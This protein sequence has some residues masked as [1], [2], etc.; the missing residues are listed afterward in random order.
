[1]KK[2]MTITGL[3]LAALAVPALA[4]ATQA[5]RPGAPKGMM[6]DIQRTEVAAQVKA[7]FERVDA[8]RDGAITMEEVQ[9]E[10]AA[11]RAQRMDAMF[12]AMDANG[13]GSISRAEFDAAH[14]DR[15]VGPKGPMK[16]GM[17]PGPMMGARPD[18]PPP[19]TD[20]GTPPPPP[21]AGNGP[22]GAAPGMMGRGG[23]GPGHPGGFDGMA[24]GQRSFVKADANKDGKVTLAEA[25]AAALA[26]FDKLDT[27]KDGVLTAK[28]RMEAMKGRFQRMHRGAH[29]PLAPAPSPAKPAK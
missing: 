12:K 19:A 27:N 28:E 7:R 29:P 4:A 21:M 5:P 22:D 3:A 13:D 15:G 24:F 1:M 9:A 14:A 6:P 8:N 20:D 25:Q 23:R 17:G 10:R 18:G 16:D 2:M 26:E 11:R